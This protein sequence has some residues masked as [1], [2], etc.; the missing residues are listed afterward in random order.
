MSQAKEK[1]APSRFNEAQGL[2]SKWIEWELLIHAFMNGS[3][4]S[5][6]IAFGVMGV[7]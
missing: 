4:R 3:L 7:P 2:T 5:D 6:W 1:N